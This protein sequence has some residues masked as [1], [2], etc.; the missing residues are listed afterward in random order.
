MTSLSFAAKLSGVSSVTSI[1]SAIAAK[2]P[3]V[4]S[5]PLRSPHH[6]A[7]APEAYVA[8]STSSVQIRAERGACRRQPN[9]RCASKAGT[10]RRRRHRSVG[11]AQ[12]ALLLAPAAT[13]AH[14]TKA[15]QR[16]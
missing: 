3:A 14:D 8:Q 1:A 13:T 15:E 9:A 7:P 12:P 16:R 6:G 5:L 2:K 10:G 4:A 11:G